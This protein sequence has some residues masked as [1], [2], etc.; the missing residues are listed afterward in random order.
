M[1]APFLT[2]HVLGFAAKR[3]LAE[4]SVASL[5]SGYELSCVYLNADAYRFSRPAAVI[6]SEGDR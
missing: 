5:A 2:P 1:A 4:S 6:C 3:R